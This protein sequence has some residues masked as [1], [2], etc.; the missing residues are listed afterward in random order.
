[1]GK[2]KWHVCLDIAGGI[3]NAKSLCGCIEVDGKTLDTVK[4]VRAFLRK[5]LAMGRRVL[6]VGECD[7]FDYQTGC[8]GH[9]VKEQEEG[10][11]EDGV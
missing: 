4:D 6:P 8:K 7:N 5:Q 11:K 1:M 10:G 3:K 2:T 9:P